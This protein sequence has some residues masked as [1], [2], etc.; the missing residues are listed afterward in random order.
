MAGTMS[1][2]TAHWG[3]S[4]RAEGRR[5]NPMTPGVGDIG[6]VLDVSPVQ[7]GQPPIRLCY[8]L[9]NGN[10]GTSA[11]EDMAALVC[12]IAELYDLR[13]YIIEDQSD[14]LLTY[15][16]AN[17]DVADY[18]GQG[19][20]YGEDDWAQSQR[21]DLPQPSQEERLRID[22]LQQRAKGALRL[23][24]AIEDVAYVEYS[25]NLADIEGAI[26]QLHQELYMVHN[27]PSAFLAGDSSGLSGE[28]LK[29][30]LL[31]FYAVS[32]PLQRTIANAVSKLLD[33]DIVWPHYFDLLEADS[34]MDADD[35]PDMEDDN[36]R[37][38]PPFTDTDNGQRRTEADSDGSG[39][40][41]SAS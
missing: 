24:D 28:S 30:L 15:R 1:Q 9:P 33:E 41:G 17:A 27:L 37:P 8:G 21:N 29:R 32:A 35:E 2:W 5:E 34:N 3:G 40:E 7:Q 16:V 38:E 14:P 19:L 13:S 26:E 22:I 12:A 25:G 39:Q 31:P 11:L 20:G 36:G 18:Q 23:E 10:W 6:E 4:D